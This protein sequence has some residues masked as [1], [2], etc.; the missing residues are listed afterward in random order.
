MRLLKWAIELRPRCYLK[1][2]DQVLTFD[3][4]KAAQAYGGKVVKIEILIRNI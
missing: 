1:L 2:N 4:R 3:T